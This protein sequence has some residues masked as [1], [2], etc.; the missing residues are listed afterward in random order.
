[1]ARGSPTVWLNRV[2][3]GGFVMLPLAP[4]LAVLCLDEYKE[5]G[6]DVR[7][8]TQLA[9]SDFRPGGD[10]NAPNPNATAPT[11]AEQ[12]LAALS[13]LLKARRETGRFSDSDGRWGLEMKPSLFGSMQGLRT[14]T[15]VLMAF[16][17][18]AAIMEQDLASL[19]DEWSIL[20]LDPDK[21]FFFAAP[22]PWQEEQIH[23]LLGAKHLR[24]TESLSWALSTAVA[25]S[26][27]FRTNPDL[28]DRFS[29]H[30]PRVR[31]IIVEAINETFASQLQDGGWSWGDPSGESHLYFTWTMLQCI[32]DIFDYIYGESS[33]FIGIE[34]DTETAA[35]L[36]GRIIKAEDKL[37]QCRERAIDFLE[38]KYVAAAVAGDLTYEQLTTSTIT[39]KRP[40]HDTSQV[41]LLYCYSYL[42]ESLILGGYDQRNASSSS[43]VM[44]IRDVVNQRAQHVLAAEAAQLT[45]ENSTLE[46]AIRGHDSRNREHTIL[47]RD[48]CLWPQLL[49]TSVLYPYYVDWTSKPDPLI[50]NSGGA[51]EQVLTDRRHENPG[52]GLWDEEAFNLSI[53]CRSIEALIDVYDYVERLERK[54]APIRPP[55]TAGDLT[56]VLADALLPHLTPLVQGFVDEYIS[57]QTQA[58]AAAAPT[59]ES[60]AD[61]KRQIGDHVQTYVRSQLQRLE[62]AVEPNIVGKKLTPDEIAKKL[63][64]DQAPLSPDEYDC[65]RAIATIAF[66]TCKALLP[67]IIAES[68][69]QAATPTQKTECAKEPDRMSGMAFDGL[70]ALAGHWS[71][72]NRPV[73]MK[74]VVRT[75]LSKPAS[76]SKR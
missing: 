48:P 31:A 16:P 35:Y 4:V 65:F 30:L 12:I 6:Y 68:V 19:F 37:T 28:A 21:G 13:D 32:A 17:A 73:D 40:E 34:R 20:A 50:L 63:L 24:S 55:T 47:Y 58:A 11:V 72:E 27:L 61:L 70:S 59:L 14:V 5:C 36:E 2:L 53:T 29:S 54:P 18:A 52:N 1:M 8:S 38:S 23:A 22:Q 33:K 56:K 71:S 66:V 39:L 74:T 7:R 62:S 46:I 69:L 60:D 45:A 51:Y 44:K 9:I 41:P 10:M 25:I 57:D 67:E 76:T 43:N 15:G 42:L 26:Y 75:A 49:R 64:E 3:F